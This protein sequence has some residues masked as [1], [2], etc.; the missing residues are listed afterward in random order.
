M[1]ADQIKRACQTIGGTQAPPAP[2]HATALFQNQV[3][4]FK[5]GKNIKYINT[6]PSFSRK[7]TFQHKISK[8][9][10]LM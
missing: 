5:T 10:H 4:H 2:P 8:S 6:V 9:G 1:A 7:S 3:F